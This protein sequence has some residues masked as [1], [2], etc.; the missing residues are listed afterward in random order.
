MY[1]FP[2][3]LHEC[4]EMCDTQSLERQT[5]CITVCDA[6]N[7]LKPLSVESS[8]ASFTSGGCVS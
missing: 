5:S 6:D 4:V 1:V 8:A 7:L 2:Q 3:S